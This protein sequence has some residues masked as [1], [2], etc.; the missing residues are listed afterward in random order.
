MP[1]DSGD[2]NNNITAETVPPAPEYSITVS[3]GTGTVVMGN[4]TIHFGKSNRLVQTGRAQYATKFLVEVR[5]G[6]AWYTGAL[7]DDGNNT[8]FQTITFYDSNPRV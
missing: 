1:F 5:D 7:L 3:G 2:P 8:K 4:R 6:L